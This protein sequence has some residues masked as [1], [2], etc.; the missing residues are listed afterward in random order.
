M[1]L[2]ISLKSV[3]CYE[4]SSNFLLSVGVRERQTRVVT[5]YGATS[6]TD[7]PVVKEDVT[8][9]YHRIKKNCSPQASLKH[10]Y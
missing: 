7:G 2:I 1:L 4:S 3:I 9:Y 8:V 5:S 10:L 6:N